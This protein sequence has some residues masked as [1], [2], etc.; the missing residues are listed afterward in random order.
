MRSFGSGGRVLHTLAQYMFRNI[1][2]Q[3]PFH[4]HNILWFYDQLSF[5]TPGPMVSPGK[6]TN[7]LSDADINSPRFERARDFLGLRKEELVKKSI[8][9]F[10]GLESHYRHYKQR[11][12]AR[13][14][15][16]MQL[17][18]DMNEE[19][20]IEKQ[21]TRD[22]DSLR[23]QMMAEIDK[24]AER[25]K[26]VEEARIR[27]I[28]E[29][30]L[31]K[32]GWR[33]KDQ[34]KEEKKQI[35]QK[36]KEEKHAKMIKKRKVRRALV[37]AR[38]KE[39]EAEEEQMKVQV[40]LEKD[41]GLSQE[42]VERNRMKIEAQELRKYENEQKLLKRARAKEKHEKRFYAKLEALRAKIEAKEMKMTE[43]ER[44]READ[45]RKRR[46]EARVLQ[47]EKSFKATESRTAQQV[48]QVT[49]F[50]LQLTDQDKRRNKIMAQKRMVAKAKQE[51]RQLAKKERKEA[52]EAWETFKEKI[53]FSS[54]DDP[55]QINL[56][57][58]GIN[59]A[60]EDSRISPPVPTGH[61]RLISRR[62]S[63]TLKS[64]VPASGL[65]R[66]LKAPTS[67][68][69]SVKSPLKSTI[70]SPTKS[71]LKSLQSSRKHILR[72]PAPLEDST[73]KTSRIEVPRDPPES[74]DSASKEPKKMKEADAEVFM[75][76]VDT[77]HDSGTTNGGDVVLEPLEHLA[78]RLSL[79]STEAEPVSSTAPP[80][81]NPKGM[82]PFSAAARKKPP[83]K[84][85]RLSSRAKS[86][87]KKRAV[88]LDAWSVYAHDQR[89]TPKNKS[90]QG[91]S[92]PSPTSGDRQPFQQPQ[93]SIQNDVHKKSK[94][95]S[96]SSSSKMS[97]GSKKGKTSPKDRAIIE[98]YQKDDS[99][100]QSPA[101]AAQGND[102]RLIIEAL[103]ADQKKYLHTLLQKER[104]KEHDRCRLL[105]ETSVEDR[106][107]L[108]RRFGEERSKV[109]AFIQSLVKKN[110]E[111]VL[112]K[113]KDLGLTG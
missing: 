1:G 65:V 18:E 5:S 56:E 35:L 64:K 40:L 67:L 34:E 75:T 68:K 93:T 3:L 14:Q 12:K 57:D 54:F 78:R 10:D 103:V 33:E 55:S 84:L 74:C 108:E 113:K 97:K 99:C 89:P 47:V 42:V 2:H 41:L 102:T 13:L 4:E 52:L 86:A 73:N 58:Y 71:P 45:I 106:P 61:M 37:T 70:K 49:R 24:K 81:S 43:N 21:Q 44:E 82:R 22:L 76:A 39:L 19:E 91:R 6:D 94:S 32:E 38:Q 8:E 51:A 31:K 66:L 48:E 9:D 112:K 109:K 80:T 95:P 101:D 77:E 79:T 104:Q 69:S 23:D 110:A 46:E 83:G 17:R 16:I 53:D 96:K 90:G 36:I 25:I 63:L 26:R 88:P 11:R 111:I 100:E 92:F 62:N 30:E 20:S 105:L 27:K 107:E 87:T 85:K 50:S 60:P 7:G 28:L 59:L 15:I 72:L 29:H 98:D